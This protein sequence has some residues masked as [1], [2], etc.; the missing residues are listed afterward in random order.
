MMESYI[1]D[2]QPDE[3][4]A[5]F[6]FGEPI[7]K[8]NYTEECSH[9]YN[10]IVK[11]AMDIFRYALQKSEISLRVYRLTTA[12]ISLNSGNYTAWHIRRKCLEQIASLELQQEIAYLNEVG[13][14]MAKVYQ[15]WHHRRLVVEKFGKLPADEEKVL[16]RLY[17]EDDKNYL[18]WTYKMWL[19]KKFNMWEAERENTL[20]KL[21]ESRTNN[22]L[23]SYRYFL[24]FGK[25]E[26][27]EVAKRETQL[28]REAISKAPNSESAW[29]FY[30]GILLVASRKASGEGKKLAESLKEEAAK[31][32]E[33]VILTD[34]SNRFAGAMLVDLYREKKE[35]R[36]SAMKVCAKMAEAD[37]L[38]KNYWLWLKD[39]IEKQTV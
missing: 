33:E 5:Q 2:W 9:Y 26:Y 17:E 14:Q 34:E 37:V 18:M 35:M 32:G 29:T 12:V 36:D 21:Q 22:S 11:T 7:A 27:A 31:F 10:P 6:E 25:E 39:G 4:L 13:K 23:W 28:A 3:R 15:Y 24:A 38:R 30:K 1:K 8:I 19:T 16:Q 20:K